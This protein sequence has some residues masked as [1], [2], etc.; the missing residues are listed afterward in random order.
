[1]Q[2]NKLTPNIQTKLI[3]DVKKRFSCDKYFQTFSHK[4]SLKRHQLIHTRIRPFQC[5][6]CD[7]KFTTNGN[8]LSHQRFKHTLE[9]PFECNDC[10]MK[11]TQSSNLKSHQR[12]KNTIEK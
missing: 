4:G 1:M 6:D 2:Q 10:D 12:S 3:V 5:N 8:L 7:M 11:F 9:K